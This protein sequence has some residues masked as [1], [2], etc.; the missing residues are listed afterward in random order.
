MLKLTFILLS[1]SAYT[2][3][4]NASTLTCCGIITGET[5]YS[6]FLMASAP[7][8]DVPHLLPEQKGNVVNEYS[9]IY[10]PGNPTI[11]IPMTSLTGRGISSC[12]K[13]PPLSSIVLF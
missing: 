6:G 10:T 5:G 12:C 4:T 8:W 9:F 13:T 11:K 2:S 1:L 3:Y 7:E